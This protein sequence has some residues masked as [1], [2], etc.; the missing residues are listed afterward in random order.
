VTERK[1]LTQTSRE[2]ANQ[3][4]TRRLVQLAT[5]GSDQRGRSRTRPAPRMSESMNTA[6]PSAIRLLCSQLCAAIEAMRRAYVVDAAKVQLNGNQ[7][8]A[9]HRQVL[10]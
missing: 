2:S 4:N 9:W 1:G 7:L 10:K 3:E 8:M 5:Q 6:S